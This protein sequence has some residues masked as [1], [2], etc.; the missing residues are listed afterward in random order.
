MVDWLTDLTHAA[1]EVIP[2]ALTITLVFATCWIAGDAYDRRA[3]AR[4][5]RRQLDRARAD[6]ALRQL[7]AIDDGFEPPPAAGPTAAT[8]TNCTICGTVFEITPDDLEPTPRYC[9]NCRH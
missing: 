8:I 7:A 1:A 3:A 5:F 2:Q 9:P 6:R 4:R